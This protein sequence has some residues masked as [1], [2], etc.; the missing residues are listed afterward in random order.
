MENTE[1]IELGEADYR[2]LAL[3]SYSSLKD[4]IKN[5]MYYY[6]KHILKEKMKEIDTQNNDNIRMGNLVDCLL[7]CPEEFETRYIVTTASKPIGL[8][9]NFVDLLYKETLLNTN[10]FGVFCGN[11]DNLIEICYEKTGF[12]RDKID[13]VKKK[14]LEDHIG[15]DYY[16]ELTSKGNKTVIE[17][18]E[19]EWGQKIADW[20]KQHPYS[21]RFIDIPN[22]EKYIVYNQLMLTCFI[23]GV[24]IKLMID[25]LILN[26]E[27]MVATPIDYKCTGSITMFPYNYLKL[28]YW[29]QMAIY[30]TAIRQH[31]PG[32]EV[33][34]LSF[35]IFDKYMKE[36]PVFVKITEKQ[37]EEAMN[38]FT[39][40]LGKPY[41]GLLKILDN[42]KWHCERDIWNT[43]KDIFDN[44]GI[45]ELQLN[46]FETEE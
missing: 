7:S 42:Y 20:L 1:L 11:L 32:Y 12:G 29:L 45:I 13:T 4:F 37:Y 24:K 16:I 14:F 6:R 9:G 10:E 38:G 23:N 26:T 30:T 31:F 33:K 34:P 17:L 35:L 28:G 25:K 41:A 8:M 27:T 21:R 3:L 18:S 40:I 15:Y 39:T 46:N 43:T 2:K 36:T 44:N 22:G 5:P 19:L